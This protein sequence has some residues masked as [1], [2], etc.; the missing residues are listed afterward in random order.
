M[1]KNQQKPYPRSVRLSPWPR[2]PPTVQSLSHCRSCLW[3]ALSLRTNPHVLGSSPAPL[4]PSLHKALLEVA[5]ESLALIALDLA[6]LDG[7][8][9]QVIIH[10]CCVDGSCPLL[11]L[12]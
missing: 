7:P 1:E 12:G 11:I 3:V 9:L 4:H 8:A 6:V 2:S 10:L 5:S